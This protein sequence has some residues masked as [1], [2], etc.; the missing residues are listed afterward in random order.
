MSLKRTGYLASALLLSTLGS[1]SVDNTASTDATVTTLTVGGSSEA[2]EMIEVLAE[3]YGQ[4]GAAEFE[5]APSSQTSGGIEGVKA[6]E[7][8][9]GGVSRKLTEAD[10][11]GELSYL[12]MVETPM[13]V[14][15]HDSVTGVTDITA[16]QIKAVYSGEI[17]N[18]QEL[19]GPD[20]TIVLFDLSEDENEKV[21]LREVYLG[22]D[23][24]IS[25]DAIVFTE[26]DE[27]VEALA[28]TDFS[29][30]TVPAEDELE[31]L[32]LSPLTIDGIQ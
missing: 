27:L 28:V 5:F 2:Y 3:A 19:G 1:C 17:T 26:D 8:D 32:P 24:A 23:L 14:V 31:E 18:W 30:A 9:I 4:T 10:L 15:V 13:V 7:L 29:M 22:T 20:E 16:E 6:D 25:P 12:P 21:V 11:N